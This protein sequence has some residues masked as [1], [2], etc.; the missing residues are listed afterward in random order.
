MLSGAKDIPLDVADTS[1]GCVS[2]LI[3]LFSKQ[4]LQ[5]KIVGLAVIINN[6]KKLIESD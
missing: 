4:S 6:F 3:W 1:G 2:V 5:N